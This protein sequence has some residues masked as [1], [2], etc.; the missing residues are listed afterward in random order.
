MASTRPKTE[1]T[2]QTECSNDSPSF[3][4]IAASEQTDGGEATVYDGVF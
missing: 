4:D 2:H 3:V 1:C